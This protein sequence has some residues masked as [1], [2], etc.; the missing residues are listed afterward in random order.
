VMSE[1]V[2]ARL[3]PDGVQS[4]HKGVYWFGQERPY[5]QWVLL[6][7]VWPCT[8]VLVVGVTRFRERERVPGLFGGF[9]CEVCVFVVCLFRRACPFDVAPASP[10]IVFKGRARVTFG[11]KM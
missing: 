2:S 9:V 6:L 4:G 10:F 7:L 11:V 3:D 1:F 8:G 5:V